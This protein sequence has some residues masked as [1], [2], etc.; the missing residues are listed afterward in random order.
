MAE[1]PE[2]VLEGGC[3]SCSPLVF[4]EMATLQKSCDDVWSCVVDE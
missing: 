3:H 2:G 4:Q 1:Q